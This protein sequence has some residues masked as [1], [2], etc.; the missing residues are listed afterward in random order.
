M[1]TFF[2]KHLKQRMIV[3]VQKA[4]FLAFLCI[5]KIF[6]VCIEVVSKSWNVSLLKGIIKLK[7]L[8]YGLQSNTAR[9]RPNLKT[10]F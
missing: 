4:K 6:P 2:C 5:V 3:Y 1:H 8:W 7:Y 9:F 10:K